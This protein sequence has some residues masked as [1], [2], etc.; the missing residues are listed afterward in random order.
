[1]KNISTIM[2]LVSISVLVAVAFL[3]LDPEST[4]SSL[5]YASERNTSDMAAELRKT[6]VALQQ[7]GFL[8]K[9]GNILLDS[10]MDL[11][12]ARSAP[13]PQ[14][15]RSDDN[16]VFPVLDESNRKQ[17]TGKLSGETAQQSH[18]GSGYT[19]PITAPPAVAAEKPLRDTHQVSFIYVSSDIRRAIVDGVFVQ[20]GEE[21]S[22]GSRVKEIGNGYMTIVNSKEEYRLDVPKWLSPIRESGEK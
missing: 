3:L 17:D 8:Q 6:E 9:A 5:P 21:L 10:S 19:A 7:V 14:A 1:M 15:V 20:E 18:I 16:H 12:S 11:L 4:R 2:L 22:D 13:K